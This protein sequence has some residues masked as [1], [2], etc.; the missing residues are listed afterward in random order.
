MGL[1]CEGKRWEYDI[2]NIVSNKTR[3]K[4]CGARLC[5]MCARNQSGQQG[6]K[7]ISIIISSYPKA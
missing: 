6:I 5:F 1:E 4:A 2:I 3:T 7:A